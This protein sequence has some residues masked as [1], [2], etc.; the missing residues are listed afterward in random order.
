MFIIIVAKALKEEWAK[1]AFETIALTRREVYGMPGDQALAI[2]KPPD[3]SVATF[4]F[5]P[6][7]AGG[8]LRLNKPN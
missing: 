7:L 6:H 3:G 1:A 5:M 2:T 8:Y 4:R